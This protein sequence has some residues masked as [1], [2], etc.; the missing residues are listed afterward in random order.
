M[1][2]YILCK[3]T[4]A[5]LVYALLFNAVA[6][7][8]CI[9]QL[10]PAECSIRLGCMREDPALSPSILIDRKSKKWRYSRCSDDEAGQIH[11][12]RISKAEN[13]AT[14]EDKH[15]WGHL[16]ECHLSLMTHL[17][18]D[19]TA[20]DLQHR[21]IHVSALQKIFMQPSASKSKS[22]VSRYV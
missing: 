22:T 3:L 14:H 5:H 16:C 10:L 4:S 11:H 15:I 2:V 18:A 1:V 21:A 17:H 19:K 9:L 8:C 13:T 6:S 7:T 20:N 12:I